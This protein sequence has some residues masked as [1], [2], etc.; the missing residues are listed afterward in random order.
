MIISSVFLH[1]KVIKLTTI[2]SIYH[3]IKARLRQAKLIRC[4]RFLFRILPLHNLDDEELI[5]L[6]FLFLNI[7]NIDGSCF[8]NTIFSTQHIILWISVKSSWKLI[9]TCEKL[10][11]L[12]SNNLYQQLANILGFGTLPV[13]S[14][15]SWFRVELTWA[16]S[17]RFTSRKYYERSQPTHVWVNFKL[18]SNNF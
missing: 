3:K 10:A 4:G 17:L 16:V 11:S 9:C 15:S 13:L 1:N 18:W 5:C 7:I 2:F 6:Y 12:T 14:R 8:A